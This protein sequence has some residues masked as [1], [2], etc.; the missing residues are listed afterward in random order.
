MIEVE[1]RQVVF[2]TLEEVCSYQRINPAREGEVDF[3]WDFRQELEHWRMLSHARASVNDLRHI[4]PDND[5]HG[6]KA[7]DGQKNHHSSYQ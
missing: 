6:A 4:N 3:T 5:V 1:Q 2:A 7:K